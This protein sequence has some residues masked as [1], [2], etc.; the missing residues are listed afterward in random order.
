MLRVR[1]NL[2]RR[3]GLNDPP[4]VHHH[5]L[6]GTLCRQTEVVS[7]EQQRGSR[8]SRQRLQMI[9][10][11][12]L[13]R[14]IQRRR[15]LVRN[16]ELRAGRESHSDENAL[17]HTTGELV[18]ELPQAFFRVL[19][20]GKLERFGRLELHGLS[21]RRHSVGSNGLLHLEPNAPDRVE[22]R[23]RVLWDESDPSPSHRFNLG[24]GHC[25]QLATVEQHLTAGDLP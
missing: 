23:H 12:L 8:V 5:K 2:G 16:E 22:I 17:T 14:H 13:H 11:D 4:P 1:E 18:R 25:R 7:D 24:A 21:A 15:R 19:Q 6:L 3:A 20:A 10:N 9:K